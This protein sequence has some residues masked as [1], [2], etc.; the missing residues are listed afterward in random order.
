[1]WKV[2]SIEEQR[3][4]IRIS[5][6]SAC[7]SDFFWHGIIFFW[8]TKK[9]HFISTNK[10]GNVMQKERSRPWRK[11]SSQLSNQ[12][13]LRFL[14][15]NLAHWCQQLKFPPLMSFFITKDENFSAS[16]CFIPSSWF[17]LHRG[18]G[19]WRFSSEAESRFVRHW[20]NEREIHKRPQIRWQ[21]DKRWLQFN[22]E[23]LSCLSPGLPV[24]YQIWFIGKPKY[25][26]SLRC[27]SRV[28][29]LPLSTT[30]S[31]LFSTNID[32]ALILRSF[33]HQTMTTNVT[34]ISTSFTVGPV[35]PPTTKS[36]QPP[37]L[38]L[39]L[40]LDQLQSD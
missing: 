8:E 10:Q 9:S 28:C 6:L 21:I 24:R 39:G 7:Q 23:S 11:W 22:P 37:P 36:T 14:K 34:V 15:I 1:M 35:K 25:E 31:S 20:I 27:W 29:F 3:R 17:F 2:S 12:L 19:A 33:T 4:V 38:L 5:K 32:V 16:E 30:S 18:K 13:Y 40:I 26:M